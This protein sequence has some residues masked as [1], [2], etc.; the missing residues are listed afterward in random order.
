[1]YDMVKEKIGDIARTATGAGGEG[2]ARR[3]APGGAAALDVWSR[4]APSGRRPRFT[5][6]QIAAAAVRI[7]D[8]EGFAALSMRRLATELD[9]GT[10]TLYHYVRT[11]QELLALVTDEVMGEVVLPPD[12]PLPGDW[13]EATTV[14]AVRGRDTLRRH[15]WV[16]DLNEDPAIGPNAVRHFDQL[17]Q[18]L[19]GL[20]V[21]LEDKLDLAAAVDSY[22]FGHCLRERTRR[23]ARPADDPEGD[24]AAAVAGLAYVEGLLATGDYPQLHALAAAHGVWG[25]WGRVEA[26]GR[27]EGLF[28]RNL[29]R[30]LDGFAAG[31][32]AAERSGSDRP[33]GARGA[34]PHRNGG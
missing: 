10:M 21:E 6:G 26:H 7:A 33:P 19:A 23:P 13:R 2:R 4:P 34:G 12:E 18:A 5:R 29:D 32:A 16:L 1:M 31:F 8:A 9:A 30:L 20:D 15:P 11:K 28:A 25:A 22:V 24:R 14:I 17:L 3:P 27:D